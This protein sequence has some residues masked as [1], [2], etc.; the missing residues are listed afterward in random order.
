LLL[1]N[2]TAGKGVQRR[3]VR[4]YNAH[5]YLINP[6]ILVSTIARC[7]ACSLAVRSSYISS[8]SLT[9]LT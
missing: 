5:A 3:R 2:G 4:P 6:A 9:Y 7:F 1:L 8:E